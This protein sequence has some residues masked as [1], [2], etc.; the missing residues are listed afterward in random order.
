MGG[1][2]ISEGGDGVTEKIIIEN[3]TDKPMQDIMPYIQSVIRRGRVSDNEKS[4]CFVSRFMDGVMVAARRNKASDTF[5]VWDEDK[6][7]TP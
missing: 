5:I 3:Q 7:K 2:E 4:Y 1:D 6:E